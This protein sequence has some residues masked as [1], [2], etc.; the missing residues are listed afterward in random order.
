MFKLKLGRS[1]ATATLKP[2]ESPQPYA[3][4]ITPL[5]INF[6]K[7][8]HTGGQRG[9]A[10]GLDLPVL[11]LQAKVSPSLYQRTEK[12]EG[13]PVHKLQ[14]FFHFHLVVEIR[15]TRTLP[16]FASFHF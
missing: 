15:S 14:R 11:A 7:A 9:A 10:G 8:P 5:R 4:R 16:A 12:Q 6:I 3:P 13:Q 1:A 2:F